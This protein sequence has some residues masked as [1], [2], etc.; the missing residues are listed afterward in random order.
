MKVNKTL[1]IEASI[2]AKVSELI[3]NDDYVN[4]SSIGEDA[5]IEFLNKHD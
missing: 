2:A 3:E 5:I 1:S 4:F